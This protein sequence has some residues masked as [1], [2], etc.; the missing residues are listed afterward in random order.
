MEYEV[1]EKIVNLK[2]KIIE[3]SKDENEKKL[4]L[5]IIDKFIDDMIYYTKSIF[6]S[7][8]LKL[9]L[10]Y[11]AETIKDGIE[12]IDQRRRIAHDNL[13]VSVKLIDN[14]CQ[15]YNV[16]MIY[17][18]LGNYIKNTD[19]L[20]N[21]S[22]NCESQVIREDISKFAIKTIS[23]LTLHN[24]ITDNVFIDSNEFN[25]LDEQMQDKTS[26]NIKTCFVKEMKNKM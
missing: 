4:F 21:S 3:N 17:G 2:I 12:E 24:L 25:H 19:P 7:K 22:K 1:I 14:V 13:I 16:P 5:S 23:A 15:I 18:K 20:L 11:R 8:S 9:L 26:E 10:I 6:I